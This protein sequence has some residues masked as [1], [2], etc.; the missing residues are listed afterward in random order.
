MTAF[1]EKGK[2]LKVLKEGLKD[3][4]VGLLFEPLLTTRDLG[5]LLKVDRRTINRLVKRGQLPRPLKPGGSNRWRPEDITAALDRLGD[6]AGGKTC[7][8]EVEKEVR[9]SASCPATEVGSESSSGELDCG[10]DRDR[11]TIW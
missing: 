8:A 5:R 9:L 11:W 1:E 10:T 6:R 7:P 3:Q 2:K 4:G